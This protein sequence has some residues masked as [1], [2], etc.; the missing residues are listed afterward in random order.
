MSR[1]NVVDYLGTPDWILKEPPVV[2]YVWE[3]T[4]IYGVWFVGAESV[5]TGG[6]WEETHRRALFIAFDEYDQVSRHE[7]CVLANNETVEENAVS[8]FKTTK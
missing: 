5:G 7:I 3:M 4:K 2:A 1:A 6:K 8:W